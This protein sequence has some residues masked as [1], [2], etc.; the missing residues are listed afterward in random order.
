MK[1]NGLEMEQMI[2][3]TYEPGHEMIK[4]FNLLYDLVKEHGLYEDPRYEDASRILLDSMT[5]F[6]DMSLERGMDV[7]RKNSI[8]NT[9]REKPLGKKLVDKTIQKLEP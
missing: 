4:A 2:K 3:E 6:Q 5:Q 7:C 8:I 1:V 9:L